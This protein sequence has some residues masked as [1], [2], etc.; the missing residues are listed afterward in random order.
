MTEKI[1][2]TKSD[3]KLINIKEAW[4]INYWCDELNLKAEELK[5]IV[6]EVGPKP[7][8]VRM[9]IAKRLLINWN[10]SY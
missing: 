2:N 9:F 3:E 4:D 5:E 6:K 7:H 8:D 10:M 1:R